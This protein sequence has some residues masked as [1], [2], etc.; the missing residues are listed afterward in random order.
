MT[1]PVIR[2]LGLGLGGVTDWPFIIFKKNMNKG[3]DAPPHREE[4]WSWGSLSS[5]ERERDELLGSEAMGGVDPTS[6]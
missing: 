5:A 4:R 3:E 6:Y 1:R 2:E